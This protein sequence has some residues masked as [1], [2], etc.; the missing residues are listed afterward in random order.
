[1]L[2]LNLWYMSVSHDAE[3]LSEENKIGL[4]AW[5]VLTTPVQQVPAADLISH[6]NQESQRTQQNPQYTWYLSRQV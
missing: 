1:M 6:D 4:S 5:H 2:T 3:H